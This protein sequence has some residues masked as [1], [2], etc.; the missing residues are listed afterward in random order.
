MFVS[1]RIEGDLDVH[2]G[3]CLRILPVLFFF[4]QAE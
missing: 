1:S 4:E 2:V 3:G